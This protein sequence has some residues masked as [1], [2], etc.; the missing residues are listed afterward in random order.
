MNN[1]IKSDIVITRRGTSLVLTVTKI[2]R[3]MDLNEGDV[4]EVTIRR[5]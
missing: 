2:V 5:K 1:E 3:L 4:V